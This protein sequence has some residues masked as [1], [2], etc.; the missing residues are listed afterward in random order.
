MSEGAVARPSS[1]LSPVSNERKD[2]LSV[3]ERKMEKIRMRKN[4]S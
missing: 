3:M 1:I 2:M 4:F